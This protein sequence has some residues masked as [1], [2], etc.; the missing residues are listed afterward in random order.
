MQTRLPL[1][2]IHNNLET[3]YRFLSRAEDDSLFQ[4]RKY[5][6]DRALFWLGDPKLVFMTALVPDARLI[7]E[8]WGYPGTLACAPEHPTHQLSLDILNEPA[9]LAHIVEHAGPGGAV[10]LVPYATTPELFQLADALQDRCGLKVLTPESPQREQLWLRDHVD[11]KSGFRSLAAQW[12]GETDI[13][14]EGF[15]CRDIH[16]AAGAVEGFLRAGRACVVK[17]DGGESGIGHLIFLPGEIDAD[18]LLAKLQADP[19]LGSDPV[20]VEEYIRS[21]PE[22]S[23]SFEYFVPPSGEGPPR[24]AYVSRQLFSSF[25]R[26]E[27]VLI[28]RDLCE[29]EWYAPAVARGTRIAERLQGLGYAGFFDIDTVLDEQ[30]RLYLLELN[31]RRTGGTFVHEFACH[32]LGPQYLEQAAI[33]SKNSVDSG[34]ITGVSA[35]LERLGDLLYPGYGPGS[36]VV[37]SVTSTLAHGEFG[38]ILVASDDR[39]LLDLDRAMQERL[40]AYQSGR[41]QVLS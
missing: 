16:Q 40:Q 23:P 30:G 7:C 29:K 27:G 24:L 34:G 22:L 9:L 28:S 10:R 19:F 14:P 8:R 13:F 18:S 26:F 36:G 17:A 3:F 32:H 41:E 12:L 21:S 33:L 39:E 38:C 11:S 1:V 35:L 15:V 5:R 20:I 25:G 37:L 4:K 2:A 31:A 6:G